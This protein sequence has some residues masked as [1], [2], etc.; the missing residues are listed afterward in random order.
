MKHF[1]YPSVWICVHVLHSTAFMPQIALS[2]NSR[3]YKT[4]SL[5]KKGEDIDLKAELGA[6]LEKRKAMEAIEAEK[7]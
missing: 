1:V 4:M 5:A 7:G 3:G 2:R 6:Y